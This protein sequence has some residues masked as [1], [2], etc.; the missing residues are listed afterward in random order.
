MMHSVDGE[1]ER[2]R[3]GDGGEEHPPSFVL[4]LRTQRRRGSPDRLENAL[5]ELGRL[6]HRLAAMM[7]VNDG[8]RHYPPRC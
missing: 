2:R 7:T 6:F 8:A 1:E 4:G 5:L 3:D